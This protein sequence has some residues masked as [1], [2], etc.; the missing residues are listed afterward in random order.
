MKAGWFHA[1]FCARRVLSKGS[2]FPDMLM[3]ASVSATVIFFVFMILN[4]FG[5]MAITRVERE[6][7]AIAPAPV[8]AIPD[9]MEPSVIPPDP[10]PD[11][12][13]VAQVETE[14]VVLVPSDESPVMESAPEPSRIMADTL[15]EIDVRRG[16]TLLEMLEKVYGHSRSFYGEAAVAANG[17]LPDIHSLRIGDRIVFPIIPIPISPPEHECF[18]VRIA[19]FQTLSDA[20]DFVRAWPREGGNIKMIPMFRNDTGFQVPVVLKTVFADRAT[21]EKA[22]GDLGSESSPDFRIIQFS[23]NDS[24]FFSDP[25]FQ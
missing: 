3:T 2:M 24:R 11:V 7:G 14:P 12:P 1:R 8:Q 23:L 16:D 15:G 6:S 5:D 18:W 25:F 19:S 22:L 20:Y 10:T 21:A 4:S 9:R 13:S 17:H